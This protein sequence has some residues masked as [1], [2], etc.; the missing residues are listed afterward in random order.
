MCRHVCVPAKGGRGIGADLEIHQILVP[1]NKFIQQI[2]KYNSRQYFWLYS[3]L[4][5]GIMAKF[6]LSSKLTDKKFANYKQKDNQHV[7]FW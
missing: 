6:A 5:G 4:L 7:Y 3:I 2:A 1:P